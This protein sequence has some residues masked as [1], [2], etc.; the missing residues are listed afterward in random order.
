M[1]TFFVVAAQKVALGRDPY[2]CP[3]NDGQSYEVS[4]VLAAMNGTED[5]GVQRAGRDLIATILARTSIARAPSP[6]VLPGQPTVEKFSVTETRNVL[7]HTDVEIA[8]QG[9]QVSANQNMEKVFAITSAE[10]S[11]PPSPSE[12]G[13]ASHDTEK[14]QTL[15]PSPRPS[16]NGQPELVT[17]VGTFARRQFSLFNDGF[18]SRNFKPSKHMASINISSS[19]MPSNSAMDSE[20]EWDSTGDVGPPEDPE[21]QPKQQAMVDDDLSSVKAS[22]AKL[23]T[24]QTDQKPTRSI[25]RKGRVEFSSKELTNLR[26]GVKRYWI[27]SRYSNPNN[28]SLNP[29]QPC[30]HI[31]PMSR[32]ICSCRFGTRW[33]D[34]LC[35]YDFHDTRTPAALSQK[36][37]KGIKPSESPESQS[38]G[39]QMNG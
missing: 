18:N 15:P 17:P 20:E 30:A 13:L 3:G 38:S 21:S 1:L 23:S 8:Q 24:V 9:A 5:V 35:A 25:R 36:W 22:A 27:L 2:Y 19:C 31:K 28:D 39:L 37:H 33:S 7:E 12:S 34:I 29:A 6:T 26:K 16:S 10:L 32:Y 14:S 11:C 4:L